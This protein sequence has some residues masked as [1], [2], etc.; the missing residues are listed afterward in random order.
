[1]TGYPR[2]AWSRDVYPAAEAL[3]KLGVRP[4]DRL[5]CFG[6]RA[7]YPDP[8]W[9]RLVGAQLFA[10]VDTLDRDPAPL[11]REYANKPE[12][13]DTLRKQGV[14]VLVAVFGRAAQEPE[15]W[16]QLGSTDL[17]ALPLTLATGTAP[18]EMQAQQTDVTA[19]PAAD[20]RH[21][22]D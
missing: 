6:D 18:T 22:K 10:Q 12:I 14:K 7:C 17:Y 19:H 15:G 5:A 9:A 13:A 3:A 8:Y 11:W 20:E 4:G 2:G 1:M 16:V 21:M